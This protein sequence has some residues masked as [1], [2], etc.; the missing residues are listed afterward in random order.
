MRYIHKIILF[1]CLCSHIIII[2]NI[3]K[4]V[5]LVRYDI[6]TGTRRPSTRNTKTMAETCIPLNYKCIQFYF[7]VYR[8]VCENLVSRLKHK[9]KS[10][11]YTHHTTQYIV[12][13]ILYRT[14]GTFIEIVNKQCVV[15]CINLYNI[16]ICW[17]SKEIPSYIRLFSYTKQCGRR[18]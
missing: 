14:K 15:M 11:L 3:I 9:K 16:H 1:T 4:I 6:W 2:I 8:C 5:I 12:D 18:I 7:R 13:R 10:H 17:E